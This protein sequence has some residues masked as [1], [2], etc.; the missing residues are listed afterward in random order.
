MKKSIKKTGLIFGVPLTLILLLCAIIFS[1]VYFET[2]KMTPAKTQEIVSDVF[3]IKD[4]YVNLF[5]IKNGTQYIVIDAGNSAKNVSKE[6]NQLKIDPKDVVALFLTHSDV[7]H[8]AALDLFSNAQIYLSKAEKQ[9]INGQTARFL[10]MKNKLTSEYKLLED[11]QTINV[12]GLKI[13]GILS[14]GHTPGSMCYLVNDT[15]LFTGDNMSLKNGKV[16]TF[17]DLFNMDSKTQKISLKKLAQLT[18]VS[19]I[20]TAHYGYTDNFKNAFDQ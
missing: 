11:N 6:L 20:F 12:A 1:T 18:G 8:I 2:K 5:I 17:N 4:K 7:D 14:V 10:F 15:Y 13:Q 3:S 19:H 16:G 9:M